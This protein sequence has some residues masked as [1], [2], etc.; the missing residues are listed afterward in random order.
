[1]LE[2]VLSFAKDFEFLLVIRQASIRLK[3]IVE[4]ILKRRALET[5]PFNVTGVMVVAKEKLELLSV[6]VGQRNFGIATRYT[7]LL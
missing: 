7:K 4:E 5:L 6:L 3:R 2:K 1:L